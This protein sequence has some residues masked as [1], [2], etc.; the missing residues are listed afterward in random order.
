MFAFLTRLFAKQKNPAESQVSQATM[1]CSVNSTG[2][3][4]AESPAAIA[5][6]ARIKYV[7]MAK[8]CFK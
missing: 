1:Y 8:C 7:K 4:E 2:L 6:H 3:E 5:R